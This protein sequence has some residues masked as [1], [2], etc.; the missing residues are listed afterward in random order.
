M[1]GGFEHGQKK[2][3]KGTVLRMILAAVLIV[4]MWIFANGS[5][6]WVH[7][8]ESLK[9]ADPALDDFLAPVTQKTE[10]PEGYTGIYT[11][12]Q[13]IAVTDAPDQNYI[14]MADID[15]S[16]Y[17]WSPLCTEDEPFAGIFDGN[18]HVISNLN[19]TNGLF[20]YTSSAQIKNVG[21]RNGYISASFDNQSW[22]RIGGIAGNGDGNI[23][24]CQNYGT[25]LSRS[26]YAHAGGIISTLSSSSYGSIEYCMNAADITAVDSDIY[27]GGITSTSHMNIRHC[28]NC[29]NLSSDGSNYYYAGGIAGDGSAEY[30]YSTGTVT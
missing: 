16:S 5:T 9:P 30:C 12:E 4:G 3:G 2:T 26:T 10:V 28:F 11:A 14:L 15:V 18:G 17:S 24:H 23:A 21:I 19:G 25:I 7:A 1:E 20:A 22:G 27:M 6:D 8:A 29:G 13:L